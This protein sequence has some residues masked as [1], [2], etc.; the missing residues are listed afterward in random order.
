MITQSTKLNAVIGFPL[1]HTLSPVLHNRIYQ[2]NNL[3]AIMLAFANENIESLIKAVRILP[4]YLTAVTMPHKEKVMYYLDEI[5]GVARKIGAV[6]TVINKSGKLVGYNTDVVGVER[7]LT[8][9]EIRNKN[10]L[11][12]GAGGAARPVAY[13]ISQVGGLP[14]YHNRS[15]RKA[16]LL[17]KEFGGQIV[18]EEKLNGDEIDIIINTTP[19]GMYPDISNLS[20][21]DQ[22]LG[23][24]H[25]VIDVVYNPCQT[26]LLQAAKSKGARIIS[27]LEMFVGQ[28]LEQV[29]LWRGR[30][31]S[32]NSYVNFLK[33]YL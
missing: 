9:V 25:T 3:D 17:V 24:H 29:R 20:L 2:D 32:D 11:I 22:L 23:Q 5:D 28:A 21:S 15:R 13:Y 7:A 8:G 18:K 14:L 27:G 4:I 6:N 10:V 31:L 26:K 30:E 12:I 33:N 19:I 16:A 1:D